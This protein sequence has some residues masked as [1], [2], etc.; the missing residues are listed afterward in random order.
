ME[1]KPEYAGKN[2]FS[3]HNETFDEIEKDYLGNE[4]E[5]YETSFVHVEPTGFTLGTTEEF[6]S[7]LKLVTVE[8]NMG[9]VFTDPRKGKIKW[10]PRK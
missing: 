9:G 1:I 4:C 2:V 6:L 8:T 3:Y 5:V 10:Q 7:L